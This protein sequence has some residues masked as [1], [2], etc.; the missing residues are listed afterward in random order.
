MYETAKSL[1]LV[2]VEVYGCSYSSLY[3]YLHKT[4][5]MVGFL[6]IKFLVFNIIYIIISQKQKKL[7]FGK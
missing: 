1:E 4:L 2:E 7:D 5:I 3:L 6:C